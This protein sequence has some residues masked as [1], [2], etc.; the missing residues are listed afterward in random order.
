MKV[1]GSTVHGFFLPD[2]TEVPADDIRP[3]IPE[4]TK[5]ST[6]ADLEGEVT[7]RDFNM[8]NIRAIRMRKVE[9]QILAA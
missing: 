9:I 8:D 4:K 1:E 5:S 3:F 2:G 6:Q 7:P